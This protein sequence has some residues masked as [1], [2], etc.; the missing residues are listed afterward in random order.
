MRRSAAFE[1]SQ[2][3]FK[4]RPG[5]IRN[6]GVFVAV[7]LTYLF[8]GIGGGGINRHVDRAGQ[9]IGMLAVVDGAG[10]KAGS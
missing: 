1:R 2:I 10:G 4:R 7:V 5:G 9:R 8:L 3:F 6:P